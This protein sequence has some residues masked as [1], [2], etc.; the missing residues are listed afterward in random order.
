MA[1]N[2]INEFKAGTGYQGEKV[3]GG[4]NRRE[5]MGASLLL[6]SGRPMHS[7]WHRLH[8]SWNRLKTAGCFELSHC[9]IIGFDHLST[10]RVVLGKDQ[11]HLLGFQR[12]GGGKFAV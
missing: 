8:G 10:V 9:R 12:G 6:E 11:I 5:D 3:S 7:R 1:V 4:K 2:G